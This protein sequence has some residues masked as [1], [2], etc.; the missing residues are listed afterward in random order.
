MLLHTML[1]AMSASQG[2]GSGEAT[3]SDLRLQSAGQDFQG[4]PGQWRGVLPLPIPG[5]PSIINK[6]PA[7]L[8]VCLV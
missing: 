6:A 5:L 3:G 1:P 2:L 4:H 7:C 8:L